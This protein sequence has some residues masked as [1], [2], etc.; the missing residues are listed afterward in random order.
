[1]NQELIERVEEKLL[2]W[3]KRWHIFDGGCCLVAAVIAKN[4]ERI[5]QEYGVVSYQMTEHADSSISELCEDDHLVH[6]GIFVQDATGNEHEFG[7]D[8][9]DNIEKSGVIRK[10]QSGVKSEDLFQI[11]KDNKW[12][13]RYP[14]IMNELFKKEITKIFIDY[15]T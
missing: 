4:L 12:N 2:D 3:K 14:T 9:V 15:W 10:I 8:F 5:K 11:Y 6:L 1:M 13:S 7:C